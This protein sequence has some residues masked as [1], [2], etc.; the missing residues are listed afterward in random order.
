MSLIGHRPVPMYYLSHLPE[1]DGMTAAK[2][3]EYINAISQYKPGIVSDNLYLFTVCP[4]ID[5]QD[6]IQMGMK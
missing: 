5:N 2:A 1:L 4:I 3:Q 6:F